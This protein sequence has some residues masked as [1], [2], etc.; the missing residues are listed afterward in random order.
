MSDED[1]QALRNARPAERPAQGRGNAANAR[2]LAA[3]PSRKD[4]RASQ[5]KEMPR[6]N[7]ANAEARTDV[8][9]PG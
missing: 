4:N 7:T 8:P 9:S 3:M 1:L 2:Q 6:S 5:M